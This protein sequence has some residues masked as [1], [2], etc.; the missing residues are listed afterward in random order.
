[1][2]SPSTQTLQQAAEAWLQGAE[3]GVVRTRSGDPYKPSAL[4][5]YRASLNE[6]VLRHF[7]SVRLSALTRVDVQD[8]ADRRTTPTA[9]W[10][11]ASTRP[12]SGTR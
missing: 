10:P 7:G 8:Y 5:S 9:S 12:R 4:R 11:T 6:R 2:R 1:M 3:D